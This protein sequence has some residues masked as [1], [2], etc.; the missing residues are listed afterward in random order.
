M[1]ILGVSPGKYSIF[2]ETLTFFRDSFEKKK[3]PGW[4]QGIGPKI[5]RLGPWNVAAKKQARCRTIWLEKSGLPGLVLESQ[6]G[7]VSIVGKFMVSI[8]QWVLYPAW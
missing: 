5:H 1:W 8:T 4:N 7:L 6:I 3:R 2:G